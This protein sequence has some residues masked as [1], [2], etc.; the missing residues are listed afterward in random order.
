[1]TY[2]SSATF[3]GGPLDGTTYRRVGGRF[4]TRLVMPVN[5]RTHLYVAIYDGQRVTYRHVRAMAVEVV[6]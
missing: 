2:L 4:P 5:G 6:A 1:M 3:L